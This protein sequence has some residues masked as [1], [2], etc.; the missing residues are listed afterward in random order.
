MITL[1]SIGSN[2]SSHDDN[3]V[4]LEVLIAFRLTCS[5]S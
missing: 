2:A 3:E 1:D 4:V 5:P